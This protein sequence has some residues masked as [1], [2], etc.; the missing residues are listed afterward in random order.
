MAK[1]AKDDGMKIY[2]IGV[3]TPEGSQIPMPEGRN[4][5]DQTNREVISSL[6]E[7]ICTKVSENGG[8]QY[9]RLD[10]TNNAQ[11]LLL[12]ELSKLTATKGKGSFIEPNEQFMSIAVIVLLLL[13][14]E[15]FLFETKSIVF[16]K[17]KSLKK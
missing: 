6:N 15:F 3:G 8:G 14:V 9:F 11:E 2:V 16:G 4:L 13:L 7:N 1:Q 5:L 10:E 12:N 17:I